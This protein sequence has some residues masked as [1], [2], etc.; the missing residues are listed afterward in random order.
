[1]IIELFAGGTIGARIHIVDRRQ[2]AAEFL[3]IAVLINIDVHRRDA[4][5]VRWREMD[6]QIVIDDLDAQWSGDGYIC[7]RIEPPNQQRV[8]LGRCIDVEE[9]LEFGRHLKAGC[10]RTGRLALQ[11]S[12]S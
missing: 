7:L 9:G 2:D 6:N 3:L 5:A 4:S 12:W 8:S 1:M 11:P 10:D